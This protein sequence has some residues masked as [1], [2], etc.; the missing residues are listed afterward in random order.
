MTGERAPIRSRV[1]S[2]YPLFDVDGEADFMW[3]IVLSL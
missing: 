2:G 1:G 3:K